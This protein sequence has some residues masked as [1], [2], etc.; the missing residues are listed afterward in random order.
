MPITKYEIDCLIFYH[1]FDNSGKLINAGGTHFMGSVSQ[2]QKVIA[3]KNETC[4]RNR[5]QGKDYYIPVQIIQK[6]QPT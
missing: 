4:E 1:K 3:E 6:C 2:L 5:A